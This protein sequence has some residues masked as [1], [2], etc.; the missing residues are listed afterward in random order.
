MKNKPS[1]I[2]ALCLVPSRNKCF[3]KFGGNPNLPESIVWPET[4]K[5]QP[6]DFLAQIHFSE[7]TEK[8]DLPESGTLFVFYSNYE[9]WKLIYTEEPLPES[10]RAPVQTGGRPWV[11]RESFRRFKFLRSSRC[12]FAPYHQ[13]LGRPYCLQHDNMAPGYKLLLQI[14]SD[15]EDNGPGWTW[16]DV[17][18]IYF[19]IRPSDLD[20]KNFD[21]VRAFWECC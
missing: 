13:M 10:G 7:I 18:I 17:G 5:G 14:D 8:T 21:N 6:L 16:G 1:V 2:K 15:L 4:S 12:K 19:F 9:N 20:E 3:T 11:Y